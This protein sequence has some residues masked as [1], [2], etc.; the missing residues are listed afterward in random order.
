MS[1][2]VAGYCLRTGVRDWRLLF[3]VGLLDFGSLGTGSGSARRA[4]GKNT[5]VPDSR[6]RVR[7]AQ[8][9]STVVSLNRVTSPDPG[10]DHRRQH[11]GDAGQLLD[12]L[13]A[14][15]MRS[16]SAITADSRMPGR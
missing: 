14:A 2:G 11:G 9:H 13:V 8:E 16:R 5:R 12:Y 6:W 10:D 15:L 7:P 4:G 3:L 1:K